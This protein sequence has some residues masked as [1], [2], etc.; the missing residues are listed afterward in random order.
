MPLGISVVICCYNSAQRITPTLQ[1]LFLQK[2][3]SL[4]SWEIIIVNNCSTDNTV[5][6]ATML[7]KSFAE[8]KPPF[9]IIDEITPG[10]SVARKKGIEA[11]DFDY[12]LFCDDDNWLNEN[13]LSVALSTMQNSPAIGVL[14]GKGIPVFENSEPPYFWVNQYHTL[15]VGK[16]SN[17]NGD[18]TDGRGVLYGAGMILNKS[19]YHLLTNHYK[20]NFLVSD[21]LGG[22]LLSSGDHELCLALKKIGYR[23][24]YNESL[25]FKHYIPANRTTIPYYKKLFLGFGSSY[26]MLQAYRVSVRKP[27]IKDDY[28]YVIIQCFKKALSASFKLLTSGY[29]FQREKYKHV[30][31][32]HGLYTN[33]GQVKAMMKLKNSFKKQL[34]MQPL[35]VD[36]LGWDNHNHAL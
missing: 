7:W 16:Q 28:R 26:A 5:E 34:E 17:I 8:D 6:V 3:I 9:K 32:L 24:F 10:L 19:A 30:D 29:Y 18:I 13:Y 4:S 11:S 14:G 15:A 27:N 35:F 25:E 2:E 33:I 21:R 31:T 22:N 23:I 36:K 1:H 20:F 12:V